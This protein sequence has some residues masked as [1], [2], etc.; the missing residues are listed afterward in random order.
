[1]A[2]RTAYDLEIIAGPCSVDSDNVGELYDMAE[3]DT[4]QG[5]AI[6]GV[7]VVGLKSRTAL[8]PGIEGQE[9][10]GMGVD[11]EGIEQLLQDPNAHV[12]LP[13]IAI[14]EEVTTKTG[15]VVATEMMMP[16]VQMPLYEGRVPEGQGLFW[17]PAINALGW[18]VREMA[19]KAKANGWEIGIKNAK[20]L[21]D[22]TYEEA[23]SPEHKGQSTLEK[24]WSGQATYANN[25]VL[26]NKEIVLIHRGVDVPGKGDYRNGLVHTIAARVKDKLP[27]ARLFLDPTHSMGPQLRDQIV[28]RTLK[29]ME[30]RQGD[31]FLY[32][33]VLFEAG[34]SKTD[35]DE[36]ITLG[37]LA[38]FAGKV[39]EFR[40]LRRPPVSV[41]RDV[42]VSGP[43]GRR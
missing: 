27:G 43:G 38:D 31:S 11:Y 34:T 30:M 35:T 14:A 10:N 33:G 9:N 25:G 21:G 1:M 40:R 29:M 28:D 18:T 12:D 5:P 17:T 13:S 26:T 36:H 16:S 4:E 39:S 23:Q 3:I 37:E 22:I 15:L 32:D 7:R 42:F 2:E 8:I 19:V 41:G 6:R 20:I 24:T